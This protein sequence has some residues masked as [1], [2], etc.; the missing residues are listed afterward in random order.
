MTGKLKLMATDPED[1]AVVSAAL[2]DAIV[3]VGDMTYLPKRRRFAAVLNRFAWE[4]AAGGAGGK[5]RLYRRVRSGIH[6]DGVLD[7]KCHNIAQDKKDAVLCLL[8]VEFEGRDGGAGEVSLM[9]AGGGIVRLDVEC[10][11]AALDDLGPSWTTRNLP[12]HEV[13]DAE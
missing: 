10:I 8:A 1:L 5:G 11:D 2:Q 12:R 3:R 4:E 7:V 6:F 9:F 13:S